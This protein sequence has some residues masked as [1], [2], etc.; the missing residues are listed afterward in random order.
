MKILRNI[1]YLLFETA[2]RMPYFTFKS[3]L[4][5]R[6]RIQNMHLRRVN[7]AA[8]AIS[9][10]TEATELHNFKVDRVILSFSTNFRIKLK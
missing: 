4:N 8:M 7:I 9:K 5:L 6:D 3:N 2:V 1:G 10:S